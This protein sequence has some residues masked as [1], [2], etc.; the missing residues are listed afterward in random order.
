MF[1][2]IKI[3]WITW[4]TFRMANNG[5]WWTKMLKSMNKQIIAQRK[6]LTLATREMLLLLLLLPMCVLLLTNE[7]FWRSLMALLLKRKNSEFFLSSSNKNSTLQATSS[8]LAWSSQRS[9]SC[10]YDRYDE[11]NPILEIMLQNSKEILVYP[12]H[13]TQYRAAQRMMEKI[14]KY[15]RKRTFLMTLD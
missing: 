13:H 12:L 11:A 3:A 10:I 9:L 4:K 8:F 5:K 2:S 14:A 15:Q 1:L 7:K 6:S